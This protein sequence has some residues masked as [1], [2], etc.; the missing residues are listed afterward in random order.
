LQFGGLPLRALERALTVD[1]LAYCQQIRMEVVQVLVEK[2]GWERRRAQ[3]SLRLY[4]E[5]AIEVSVRGAVHDVCRDPQ[6]D[7]I[8]ECAL[9]ADASIIVTGDKDLLVVLQYRNIRIMTA[10]Q[11]VELA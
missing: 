8:L 1:R 7:M 9:N 11:Y 2:L 3:A 5:D 6:D 4:L 10:R